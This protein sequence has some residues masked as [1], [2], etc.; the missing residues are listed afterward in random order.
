MLSLRVFCPADLSAEAEQI[1][2]EEPSVSSLAVIPGGSR[3]PVGDLIIASVP[4]TTADRVIERL[5]ALGVPARGAIETTPVSGWTS[6]RALDIQHSDAPDDQDA[7]VWMDVVRDA[8][9]S[10]SLT[11]GFLAFM[12]MATF[13]AAIAIVLDSQVLIIGAMVLGPEFGAIA[14]LGVALVTH[15]PHLLWSALRTLL[16][17]FAIAIALSTAVFALL[18]QVGWV[19]MAQVSG[20]RPLT[21]FIYRPD[22][23]SVVIAIVA[24][25][26][27]VLA[28]VTG[29][30][31]TLTG[32]FISVTTI[33]AAGNIALALPFRD[34]PEVLGSALQLG[35][36]IT[37]MAVAGSLTLLVLRRVRAARRRARQ[38]R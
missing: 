10:S 20:P 21:E 37:G 35:I 28:L 17:G 15:R 3:E 38:R 25:I 7:V 32:V 33:P 18:A 11:W 16:L 31:A 6:Q 9:D 2:A 24:G 36:N 23:W 8:Y 34:W 26:A 22:N 27:G 14:A 4:R 12:S 5:T 29:R 19:T 1:L 30:S 13:I